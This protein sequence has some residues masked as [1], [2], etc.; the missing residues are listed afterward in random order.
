MQP[1]RM[2]RLLGVFAVYLVLQSSVALAQTRNTQSNT[3]RTTTGSTNRTTSTAGSTTGQQQ[4]MSLAGPQI[5]EL[6]T[7]SDQMSTGFIGRNTDGSFV[8]AN[9]STQNNQ[10]TT[11]AQ[12]R[13]QNATRVNQNQ[14]QQPNN[15]QMQQPSRYSSI[16]Y[17]APHRVAFTAPA[18]PASVI[19]T[20][21]TTLADKF[22][23]RGKA[24]F[25]GIQISVA[26]D[27]TVTLTGT[28]PDAEARQKAQLM[29]QM[30]PGV[31]KVVNQ[32]EVASAN[33]ADAP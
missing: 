6:G 30:E 23:K 11:Q 1:V 31:Y 12:N 15:Q 32:L 5:S 7:L 8:G 26:E 24:E 2:N 17:R 28:V 22:A 9:Q 33:S 19:E 20:R 21:L 13:N 18:R 14:F 27:N 3:G 4:Q 16:V 10:T 29:T 25:S